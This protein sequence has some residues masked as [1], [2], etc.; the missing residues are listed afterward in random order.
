MR[1]DTNKILS[2]I[3]PTFD[4][5]KT[6]VNDLDNI[7]SVLENTKYRYEIIVVVDGTMVDKTY[8]KLKKLKRKKLK[9]I[10]YKHNRG[11]GYAV[12]FGMAKAKGN[13]IAFIDAGGDLNP[14]GITMM[15]EHMFWYDADIIIGSKLHPVSK[16]IYPFSRRILSIL[17]RIWIWLLFGLN[18]KDTQTGMKLFKY[19]VLEKVLPRLLVKQFAFDIEM[20]AVARHLGFRRIYESPVELTYNF[21]S[22][23]MTKSFISIIFK[24]LL[25]TLAIF[26][27]L[28]IRHYYDEKNQR[29][30]CYDPE[31]N[32]NINVG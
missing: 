2:V 21:Q 20:L 19:K 22:T 5:E 25:D 15:L 17:S 3:V 9:L 14:N 1:Q 13:Y 28:N 12:R 24:T 6:I 29:K 8:E 26:Y 16:V 27:R 30:W 4:Q 7:F 11:K 23:I 18:V 31:L 32:F 10:G